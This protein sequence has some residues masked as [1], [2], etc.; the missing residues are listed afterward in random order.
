MKNIVVCLCLIAATASCKKDGGGP[1]I[2]SVDDDIQFGKEFVAEFESQPD[3]VILDSNRYS[4]AYQYLYGYRDLL[5]NTGKL[6]YKDRFEWRVRI[7]KDDNTVNAF[8]LP[9]G[10]LYVYTGLIKALNNE[11]EFTGVIGH[12]LAH[13][14]RRHSTDQM[15]RKYGMGV[16]LSLL[17]GNNESMWADLANLG[18]GL[19]SLK[20]D[21]NFEEDAD[22]CAVEYNYVTDLDARGVGNFFARQESSGANF[23]IFSTHP[24][25]AKRVAK[26]NEKWKALGGKEGLKNESRYQA[27]KNTLP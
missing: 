2:F 26:V 3:V 24:S 21:R 1:N 5:L 20:F 27:F 19:L 8:A 10:Y 17:L 11:A 7:I 12:E 9:G 18:T 4:E 22:R 6:Q 14:D 23:D 13:S 15:T 16:L 25:D